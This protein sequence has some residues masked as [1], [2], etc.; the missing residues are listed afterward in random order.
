MMTQPQE[1]GKIAPQI[2]PDFTFD[3]FESVPESLTT[4]VFAK[5][6]SGPEVLRPISRRT[7][8]APAP[9]LAVSSLIKLKPGESI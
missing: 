9:L 4:K 1:K 6:N 3:K 7:E 5:A 2:N 8:V